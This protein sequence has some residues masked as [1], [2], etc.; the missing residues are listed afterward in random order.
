MA[1]TNYVTGNDVTA[2][3]M[4]TLGAEVIAALATFANVYYL[5]NNA[6]ARPAAETVYW[7][8]WP[9]NTTPTNSAPGDFVF[10]PAAP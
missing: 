10:V 5:G 9:A 6:V 8:N 1:R 4:N 2:T 7:K 3:E